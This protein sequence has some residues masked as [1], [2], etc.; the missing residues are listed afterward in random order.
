MCHILKTFIR[1]TE[2]EP[3]IYIGSSLLRDLLLSTNLLIYSIIFLF[4]TVELLNETIKMHW[5]KA[6]Q[7]SLSS[8]DYLISEVFEALKQEVLSE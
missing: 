8:S 3:F 5:S 4:S 2:N 7:D 1:R 6:N